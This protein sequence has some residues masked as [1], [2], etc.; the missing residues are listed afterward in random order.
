V[1]LLGRVQFLEQALLGL[2]RRFVWAD[3]MLL[4][5]VAE[6]FVLIGDPGQ[7][8]PVVSV[9]VSRWETSPRPAIEDPLAKT[10]PRSD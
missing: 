1:D 8:S 4:G 3:F 6:R 9:N 5:Q 2:L 7:I 10:S